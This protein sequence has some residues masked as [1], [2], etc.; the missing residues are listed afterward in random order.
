MQYKALA[1]ALITTLPLFAHAQTN[2]TIYGVMDAAIAV[3]D[4]DAPGEKR[5]CSFERIY[6]SRGNDPEIYAERKALG[7]ALADDVLAQIRDDHDHAVFSYIPNTAEIAWYGLME[8]LR[9]RRRAQVREKLLEAR[10]AGTLDEAL[11]DRLVLGGV[12]L[13]AEQRDPGPVGLRVGHEAEGVVGRDHL[14]LR[15]HQP[16][17][18]A[19]SS[20]AK[21]GPSRQTRCGWP[22]TPITTQPRQAPTA[23]P[24]FCSRATW[25]KLFR[26]AP[27]EPTGS[28]FPPP[29]FRPSFATPSRSRRPVAS[30]A[31]AASIGA[32]PQA[33][34]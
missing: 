14:P 26:R 15:L 24:M 6:F 33:N 10:R 31:R 29:R 30:F 7:A 20:E 34:D 18:Q 21:T 9:K 5:H 13:A 3:E 4:T 19:I 16:D 27:G 23:Q 8:E 12:D 17:S 25:R 11:I 1:A 28:T 2:V 32:G 22:E